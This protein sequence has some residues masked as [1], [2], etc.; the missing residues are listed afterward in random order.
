MKFQGRSYDYLEA[1]P[2]AVLNP[3]KVLRAV[4]Q[5]KKEISNFPDGKLRTMISQR[6]DDLIDSD[7]T[8]GW[9]PLRDHETLKRRYDAM[10]RKLQSDIDNLRSKLSEAESPWGP[11]RHTRASSDLNPGW[12][13]I[14]VIFVLSF[15]F[16]ILL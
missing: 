14:L 10:E 13:F 4:G 8:L 9:V 15:L 2:S 5:A 11:Q 6:L 16:T 3:I 12:I 7:E 1:L